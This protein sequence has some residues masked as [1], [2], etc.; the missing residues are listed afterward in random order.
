MAVI[1]ILRTFLDWQNYDFFCIL[2]VQELEKKLW[3]WLE[4]SGVKDN[5]ERPLRSLRESTE[6]QV[7]ESWLLAFHKMHVIKL[8]KLWH[9]IQRSGANFIHWSFISKLGLIVELI[10]YTILVSLRKHAAINLKF[11]VHFQKLLKDLIQD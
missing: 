7:H 9:E 5:F 3:S 10:D 8:G 11:V 6:D 4:R 1:Y 2:H